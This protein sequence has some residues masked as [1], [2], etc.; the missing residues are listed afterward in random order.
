MI[1]KLVSVYS[2]KLSLGICV[3]SAV[4]FSGCSTS[5]YLWQ[6]LR[7]QASLYSHERK[8]EEVLA[9]PN[10]EPTVKQKLAE[11]S[12][13]KQM[14]SE[15]LGVAPTNNYTTFVDIKRPA[16]VKVL[17]VVKP[18]ELAEKKW[19]MPIVGCFGYLGFFDEEMALSWKRDFERQGYDTHLRGAPAYSTLGYLRDP[20]IS[21]MLS[22][23]KGAMVNLIF[24]ESTHSHIFIKNNMNM[25]EEVASFIGEKAEEFF[26]KSQPANRL[27]RYY[28]IRNER[29]EFGVILKALSDELQLIY[30][31]SQWSE[32][33][34]LTKKQQSFLSAQQKLSRLQYYGGA[35]KEVTNN[36]AL[37]AFLT[38]DDHQELY[39]ELFRHC[40]EDLR[41]S[42]HFLKEFSHDHTEVSADGQESAL[43]KDDHGRLVSFM[44]SHS[45][46]N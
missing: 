17:T 18:L 26:L 7:G 20:L 2:S 43:K 30:S 19:C 34:K 46:G 31:S 33:I 24:H 5:K 16:V 8:I 3:F 15:V 6:A 37:I 21:S 45:C 14:V 25:N 32:D 11:I 29:K 23:D 22:D 4:F 12:K 42:F 28:Q 9:D 38:Y 39:E 40:G 44:K 1:G 41:R 10:V 13:I 36:A 35:A 27:L